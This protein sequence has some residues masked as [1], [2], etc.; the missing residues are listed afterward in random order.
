M[1]PGRLLRGVAA[2]ALL[3]A[4]AAGG[5]GLWLASASLPQTGGELRLAAL[6]APVRIVR[7][8]HGV[9]LIE[10]ESE[11][12]AWLALG[13]VHAQDRLWQM[14]M[15]RRA[16]H[17]RLAEVLG[18]D[19]LAV[20]RFMR[21]L[22]LGRAAE[23]GLAR[24]EP[25]AR[26]LLEAYAAGVNALIADAGVLPPE[27]LLLRH[28][29]EPWK[30]ADSLVFARLMAFQLAG[31]WRQ[32]LVRAGLA[33]RL[34]PALMA[35]L[36]PDAPA[37]AP[38]TIG[39]S[40]PS[41]ARLAELAT[42]GGGA[43]S[44]GLGSNIFALSGERTASGAPLLASD[45]HL[46]LRAPGVWYLA[47]IAAPGMEI[48]GGTMPGLPAVIIGRTP[49]VAWGFTTT[50]AD[51]DDIFLERPD[52]ADPT[53]YLVPGGSLP[54]A[55]RE[56][57]IG[58]RGGEPVRHLVRETRHGPVLSDLPGLAT[59]EGDLLALSWTGLDPAD[60]TVAAGF[61]MA[62]ARDGEELLQALR[63]FRSPVQNVAWADREGIG[64]AVVGA[65]PV[66][67]SG[68]GRLPARG[69]SGEGDWQGFL[70]EE[71]L[72]RVHGPASG[73]LV[74]ANNAVVDSSFPH[75]ITADWDSPLRAHRLEALLEGTSPLGLA[76]A[77][78]AQ[79]DELSLLA[80][81]LL[82][83]LRAV[84]PEDAV[85]AEI[86]AALER[87][88]G[89]M[90]PDAPEPLIF[91]A[92]QEA[93]AR[94]VALDELGE[95]FFDLRPRQADLL[96]RVAGGREVWCDDIRSDA[97]ESCLNQATAAFHGIL[98]A[99]R[100]AHGEDW[101]A[102][103]W[104]V[105]HP[106]RMAHQ[107]FERIPVLG[108]IFGIAVP[109]GGDSSTVDVAHYR[110]EGPAGPFPTVHAA[111]LRMLVDMAENGALF[112][113]ATGQS[114]HPLSTHHDDLAR[115]WRRG[116]YLR[117]DPGASAEETPGLLLLPQ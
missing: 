91:A 74:N 8:R 56:E 63:L 62:R 23:A 21:T 94:E 11:R 55:T 41:E 46:P 77:Q 12:D 19:A 65:V 64:L 59:P 34:P 80:S 58:V 112:V 4:L 1:R 15:H 20:D 73:V 106:A 76:A 97:T 67:R 61:A 26:G 82:P 78:A 70:P 36:W 17:G 24:L 115:L 22:G 43:P 85:E 99:L 31:N 32:E 3:A 116:T 102:W 51:T 95:H 42:L 83:L 68:D 96:V 6:E 38:V 40:L 45:P 108:R 52:P 29:P 75:L 89:H 25:E 109:D 71:A 69:W 90:A 33:R 47:R 18:P 88:D 103:R 105:A 7:D 14:E 48:M 104:G 16:G 13:F 107:P 54:F 92:W 84:P 57:L 28:R 100:A 27:F 98:P 81:A 110:P 49:G 2:V 86:L 117:L 101:R 53:R 9:P 10:A 87:W 113:T 50:N 79:H 93:F 60:T 66:R 111:G 72:P 37:D 39:G 30:V 44:A 114:G 5:A 35:D